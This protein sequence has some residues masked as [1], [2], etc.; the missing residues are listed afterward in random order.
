LTRG[1]ARLASVVGAGPTDPE[2]LV[3]HLLDSL[4]SSG[5]TDDDVAILV[6]RLDEGFRADGFGVPGLRGR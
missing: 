5:A 6:V 2:K 4:L 1:F 3:E